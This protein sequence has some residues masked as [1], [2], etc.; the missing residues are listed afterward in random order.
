MRHVLRRTSHSLPERP[1]ATSPKSLPDGFVLHLLPFTYE[2]LGSTRTRFSFGKFDRK[3]DQL[4]P[5]SSATRSFSE[6]D[7]RRNSEAQTGAPGLV[8]EDMERGMLHRSG[9]LY[10]RSSGLRRLSLLLLAKSASVRDAYAQAADSAA[11]ES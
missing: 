2:S 9:A 1:V 3:R 11:V 8:F 4:L 5:H 7:A 6:S 10:S